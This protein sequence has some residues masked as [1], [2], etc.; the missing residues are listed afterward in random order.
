MRVMNLFPTGIPMCHNPGQPG[1]WRNGRFL[2]YHPHLAP[3][4]ASLRAQCADFTNRMIDTVSLALSQQQQG[5]PPPGPANTEADTGGRL[6][7]AWVTQQSM[8][9]ELRQAQAQLR[10]ADERHC[11]MQAQLAARS[12]ACAKLRSQ[13]DEA[14]A[15]CHGLGAS[16]ADRTEKN[17]LLEAQLSASNTLVRELQARAAA[18]S[19]EHA[20]R[21]KQLATEA[22]D[23][24]AV[25]RLQADLDRVNRENQRLRQQAA[26]RDSDLEAL[27]ASTH[28]ASRGSRQRNT[29]LKQKVASLVRDRSELQR[30]L[31]TS[32]ELGEAMSRRITALADAD[33]KRVATEQQLQITNGLLDKFKAKMRCIQ[34]ARRDVNLAHQNGTFAAARAG[35]LYQ[36]REEQDYITA[37]VWPQADSESVAATV[38]AP[39]TV[40]DAEREAAMSRLMA[41]MASHQPSDDV[42]S[43][44]SSPCMSAAVAH[45]VGT[46][47][48]LAAYCQMFPTHT[49]REL[50]LRIGVAG[51]IV[52]RIVLAP[53]VD[54]SSHAQQWVE[55]GLRGVAALPRVAQYLDSDGVHQPKEVPMLVGYLADLWWGCFSPSIAFSRLSTMLRRLCVPFLGTLQRIAPFRC[56]QGPLL[57]VLHAVASTASQLG[58]NTMLYQH[59]AG[60]QLEAHMQTT[61]AHASALFVGIGS[62]TT[63][64][65]HDVPLLLLHT[66]L[67]DR[68]ACGCLHHVFE[69]DRGG[70]ADDADDTDDADDVAAV[71]ASMCGD[72]MAY[73]VT[74]SEHL[75][76]RLQKHARALPRPCMHVA[77]SA[78]RGTTLPLLRA[79]ESP[80]RDLGCTFP[81]AH[82]APAHRADIG[83]VAHRVLM[84][85]RFPKS[86]TDRAFLVTVAGPPDTARGMWR[87]ISGAVDAEACTA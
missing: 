40:T 46:M 49:R 34:Q 19:K 2:V 84:D 17:S 63:T 31:S 60:P 26:S 50:D 18:S 37:A 86:D 51:A 56:D 36:S 71:A 15:E 48:R 67:D 76:R 10:A 68:V 16:L 29:H 54:A 24:D 79:F 64:D 66:V 22:S 53:L 57:T 1:E 45:T 80:V 74:H 7:G 6:K 83:E 21:E 3:H 27:K 4:I 32:K 82:T 55:R 58:A 44:L 41:T 33:K 70:K 13:L 11:E 73:A 9:R 42:K 14:T 38:R 87:Y 62:G 28:R 47:M 5:L 59:A 30:E 20:Q 81:V 35:L 39:T 25:S 12:D 43:A 85:T 52:R 72:C 65:A 75:Q 78:E 61:F 8:Q 77:R 69:D 23:R